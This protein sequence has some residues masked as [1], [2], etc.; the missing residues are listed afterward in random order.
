MGKFF[1]D[2]PALAK[3]FGS[4]SDYIFKSLRME[5]FYPQN[6]RKNHSNKSSGSSW[7]Y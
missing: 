5:A 6:R 2:E 4:L 7:V 3:A 1:N